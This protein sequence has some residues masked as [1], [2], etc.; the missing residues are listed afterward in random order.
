MTILKNRGSDISA[1][2]ILVIADSVTEPPLSTP[3]PRTVKIEKIDMRGNGHSFRFF[4][5]SASGKVLTAKI[6]KSHEGYSAGMEIPVS[7]LSELGVASQKQL[8]RYN[9]ARATVIDQSLLD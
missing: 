9:S 6:N 8:A 7:D 5:L 1:T 2:E 4:V 3:V